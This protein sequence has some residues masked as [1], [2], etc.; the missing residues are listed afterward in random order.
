MEA[1]LTKEPDATKAAKIV[2]DVA[3]WATEDQL[4][5]REYT[6]IYPAN[7]DVYKS[8]DGKFDV[9]LYL[10]NF[11]RFMLDRYK[12]QVIANGHYKK[13]IFVQ[14]DAGVIAE[15]KAAISKV[16]SLPE[17]PSKSLLV[18]LSE[19]NEMKRHVGST[20]S[21]K[22]KI[23]ESDHGYT[24]EIRA[25][26]LDGLSYDPDVAHEYQETVEVSGSYVIKPDIFQA[27]VL[28]EIPRSHG[29]KKVLEDFTGLSTPKPEAKPTAALISA[30][31]AL[32]KSC[33]NFVAVIDDLARYFAAQ[34]ATGTA[35]GFMP[36]LLVGAPGIGKTH[37]VNVIAN[38]MGVSSKFINLSGARD[39]LKI[40]GI[41]Q[42]WGQSHPG[43]IARFMADSEHFNPII[44]LDEI[45]KC[46]S[47]MTVGE[48]LDEV[49]L[50]LLERETSASF[51]D[52]YI[53][54]G[55]D[56]SRVSWIAT[57]NSVKGMSAA[58]LSRMDVYYI[59]PP[60]RDQQ[61]TILG[62]LHRGIRRD[63]EF[64]CL[65]GSLSDDVTDALIGTGLSMRELRREIY[66]AQC[67]AIVRIPLG[68]GIELVVEDIPGVKRDALSSR[69]IGFTASM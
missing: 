11:F 40:K 63:H 17:P 9:E 5:V 23:M 16:L 41:S 53:G 61:R 10:M 18:E 64:E 47:G 12:V 6:S 27:C 57:C 20:A 67:N 13:P 52:D 3:F 43:S 36:I 37:F 65:H 31:P 46:G 51:E 7:H 26:G 42:S 14:L 35:T 8:R 58:M 62:N 60:T 55:M 30:M 33:P 24:V 69:S 66:K 1:V 28:R 29:Q 59:D 15:L 56:L 21:I 22:D 32:R 49:L 50:P 38:V 54:V 68:T 39:S 2:N 48:P 45:D 34:K 25:D 4:R 44:V 19:N